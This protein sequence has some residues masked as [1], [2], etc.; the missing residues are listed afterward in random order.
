MENKGGTLM[1]HKQKE[2]L[3]ATEYDDHITL[4]IRKRK[5]CKV[6]IC[7]LQ[8][9]LSL[10]ETL[11]NT[12]RGDLDKTIK[13]Y[14]EIDFEMALF[15]GRYSICKVEESTKPTNAPLTKT[16]KKLSTTERLALID[17]LKNL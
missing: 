5:A 1:Y 7:H 9:S 10:Y 14:K 4:Y 3:E 15:D 12:I 16:I 17:E 8:H 6:K 11:T 13:E 2:W